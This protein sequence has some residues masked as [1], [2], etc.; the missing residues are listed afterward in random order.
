MKKYG[1]S[2]FDR[3]VRYFL[4]NTTI[5]KDIKKTVNEHPEEFYYYNNGITI[6]CIEYNK[7]GKNKVKLITPQVINGAQTLNSIYKTYIEN[8]NSKSKGKDKGDNH[9]EKIKVLAMLIEVPKNENDFVKN[10]TT[11]R[12][13]NNPIRL[14]DY[15]GN[16]PIQ[17]NIQKEMYKLGY[18]YMIKRGE[19]KE[20][21]K[22]NDEP[23]KHNVIDNFKYEE[24]LKNNFKTLKLK[25]EHIATIM[26]AYNGDPVLAKQSPS[27]IFANDDNYKKVFG[28]KSRVMTADKVKEIIIVA[29]I[30][31]I[32]YTASTINI[33]TDKEDEKK[34][35]N[36]MYDSVYINYID[37]KQK[38][39][40][41][42]VEYLKYGKFAILAGISYMWDKIKLKED[43]ILQK[44]YLNQYSEKT[45]WEDSI[46][47]MIHR[48][49]RVIDSVYQN[50]QGSGNF[51]NYS[52][53]DEF[54][55][56]LKE[57]LNKLENKDKEDFKL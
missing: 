7:I 27:S 36:I 2:L 26:T 43:N 46:Y 13:A 18:F 41:N 25:I 47:K 10:I 32:I 42:F 54:W 24:K 56:K 38:D 6:T 9:Y 1:A 15:K 20:Y 11:Y 14:S 23:I 3:N 5:N 50:K 53:K 19:D 51:I 52:K 22:V 48:M 55:N 30:Y 21:L 31:N 34:I 44:R 57:A 28:D 16:C 33:D 4:G 40:E 29:L 12:N 37:E 49:L 17:E 8:E 45:F 39:I 35:L